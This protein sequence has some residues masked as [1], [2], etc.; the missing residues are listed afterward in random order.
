MF[1]SKAQA[2]DSR[3]EKADF[4]LDVFSDS[5]WALYKKYLDITCNLIEPNFKGAQYFWGV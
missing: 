1:F 4:Q 2:D 5:F 3:V